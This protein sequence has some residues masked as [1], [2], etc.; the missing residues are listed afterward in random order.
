MGVKADTNMRRVFLLITTI[1]TVV[2][3]AAASVPFR[4]VVKGPG[5]HIEYGLPLRW[6]ACYEIFVPDAGDGTS[7][8]ALSK[9]QWVCTFQPIEFICDLA[10]STLI[11][12][13]LSVLTLRFWGLRRRSRRLNS[14]M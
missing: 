11:G 10:F 8:S 7:Q 3:F 5:T 9:W 1:Y 6:V 12:T 13:G 2:I 14:A 4:Y